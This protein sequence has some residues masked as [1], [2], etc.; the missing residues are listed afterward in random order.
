MPDKLLFESPIKKRIIESRG[1]VL[2]SLE[3]YDMVVDNDVVIGIALTKYYG[4]KLYFALSA[5]PHGGTAYL[6]EKNDDPWDVRWKLGLGFNLLS[7]Y[8]LDDRITVKAP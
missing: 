1:E 2:I 8:P 5:T 7:S 6:R 4:D 3:P